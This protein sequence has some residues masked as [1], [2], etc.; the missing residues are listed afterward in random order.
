MFDDLHMLL[1]VFM[2]RQPLQCEFLIKTHPHH[3]RAVREFIDQY[4]KEK[5]FVRITARGTPYLVKGE[6]EVHV[7]PSCATVNLMVTIGDKAAA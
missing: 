6:C 7:Q 5:P 2:Q 4:A 1:D 3:L